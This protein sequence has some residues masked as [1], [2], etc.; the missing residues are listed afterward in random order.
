MNDGVGQ[1][2]LIAL[3]NFNVDHCDAM[4]IRLTFR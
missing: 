2:P 4:L 1:T 3:G